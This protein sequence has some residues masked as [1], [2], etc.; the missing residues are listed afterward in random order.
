MSEMQK[1]VFL[2]IG[3]FVG[4]PSQDRQRCSSAFLDVAKTKGATQW[5]LYPGVVSHCQADIWDHGMRGVYG[6]GRGWNHSG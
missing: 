4:A 1:V 6:V 5:N 2:F 3:C